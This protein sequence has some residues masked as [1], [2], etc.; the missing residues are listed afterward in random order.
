MEMRKWKIEKNFEKRTEVLNLTYMVGED[1]LEQFWS[2]YVAARWKENLNF[3]CTETN[4]RNCTYALS[5]PLRPSPK[6]IAQYRLILLCCFP[7]R[8]TVSLRLRY[9]LLLLY[10]HLFVA[11]AI[12]ASPWPQSPSMCELFACASHTAS[13]S[14]KSV[15]CNTLTRTRQCFRRRH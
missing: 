3:H 4:F 9:E 14:S 11:D 10:L 2:I 13:R 8:A 5:T 15:H 6:L 7:R 1:W 12:W